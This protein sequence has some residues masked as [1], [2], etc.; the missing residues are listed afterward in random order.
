MC[1]AKLVRDLNGDLWSPDVAGEAAPELLVNEP[2]TA[3]T[4][5]SPDGRSWV[6]VYVDGS[7]LDQFGHV[8]EHNPRAASARRLEP[9]LLA[10]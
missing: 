9:A 2:V 10:A 1:I 3:D 4:F 8:T 6:R 7:S 5:E